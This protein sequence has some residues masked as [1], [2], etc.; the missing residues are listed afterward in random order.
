LVIINTALV[1]EEVFI[2][3]ESSLHWTVVVKLGLYGCNRGR[4]DD[5]GGLALIFQPGLT[6]SVTGLPAN[7][8]FT[9][10]G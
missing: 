4:V 9:G 5:R 7:S 8:R 3:R 2:D 6:L 1:V 10:T